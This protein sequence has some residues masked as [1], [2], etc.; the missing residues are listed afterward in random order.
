MNEA[1]LIRRWTGEGQAQLFEHWRERPE[2]MRRRLLQDLEALDPG[3]VRSLVGE[4]RAGPMPAAPQAEPLQPVP[5]A[6]W[7]GRSDVRLL[8]ERLIGSGAAGFLTAAGGQGT[9]LGW[10]G[11][12]GCFPISPIRGASLFQILAE[13]LLAARRR[14]G[15]PMPW[16]IMTS[17][18][19]HSQT[20]DFFRE[21]DFFGLPREEIV[22]FL[23]AMLPTLTPSGKLLLAADGGLAWHP[24]GHGGTLEALR[25][26]GLLEEMRRRG[27]EELFYCQV[28]NPLVRVPDPEFAG[29]HRLAGSEMS[30]KVLLKS[31]PEE[32]LG[33]PGLVAG[34]PRIIEYSELDRRTL[35]ER[36]PDG[37]LRFAYGSIA[38]HLLNLP[39]L[40]RSAPSLPLHQARKKVEVLV[41]GPGIGA[42]EEREVIKMEKFIFDA[43]PLASNP[44]FLETEREEE[45]APLKNA[46][47]PDSIETCRD[48][49]A[50]QQARWLE[51]CGVVVPEREGR[52]AVR[53]EISPLYADSQEA[54]K[55]RLAGTVNRIDEDTLL[56]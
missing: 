41:P 46:S 37:R 3:L 48:G 9:R 36:L 52:P 24:G 29:F 50:R 10:Q 5:L 34:R 25:A 30:S 44:Q 12:K 8:G 49:L 22:F 13:K 32:K 11:P 33:V 54:L 26:A 1:A 6:G 16:Y 18:L 14:Y 19:N 23:Q 43:I 55:N 4:L 39:F 2:A 42:Q 17:P 38:V 40:S 28:D 7:R 20:S 56:V 45:F 35:S 31:S 21:Q 51:R 53:I 27:I 15:V 47:G